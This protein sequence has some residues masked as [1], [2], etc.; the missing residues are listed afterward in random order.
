MVKL[1][2]TRDLKSLGDLA[3]PVQVRLGP[4][5]SSFLTLRKSLQKHRVYKASRLCDYF[6]PNEKY[7]KPSRGQN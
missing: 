7:V 2:D 6:N 1:V 4:P 5:N 3:V